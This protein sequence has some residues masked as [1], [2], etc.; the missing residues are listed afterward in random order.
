MK[1]IIG[2]E[3][4]TV[5]ITL[6]LLAL[7]LVV[8][9]TYVYQK[10]Q[11]AQSRL[12]ELEPRYARLLGL[13]ANGDALAQSQERAKASIAQYVYPPEQDTN[14][15]GNAVQQRIRS[16]LVAAGLD[17][18][19]SQV[20]PAKEEKGF[21]RIPLSVRAEGEMVALQAGLAGLAAETPVILIDNV[22]VQGYGAP[23]KNGVQRLSVQLS[24]AVLRRHP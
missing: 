12:D 19:S 22:L 10:H 5:L 14:Q 6:A 24:L 20:L 1:P 16:I 9:A 8:V 17:I 23:N 11:W 3:V 15:T 2:R 18:A 4:T 13:D 21:E 7:P